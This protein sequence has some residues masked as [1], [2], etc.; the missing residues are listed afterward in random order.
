M[1]KFISGF[2]IGALLF[3]TIPVF[4]D[5]INNLVGKKVDGVYTVQTS[6]G[7]KIADAAVINGSTYAPVR[8]VAEATG[9]TLTVEGKVITLG[10]TEVSTTNINAL[11]DEL[12]MANLRLT[13]AQKQLTKSQEKLA[14]FDENYAKYQKK[15]DI[16]MDSGNPDFINPAKKALEDLGDRSKYEN[17]I[18]EAEES[19]TTATNDIKQIESQLSELQK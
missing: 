10:E 2:V 14:K 11:N 8:A 5:T 6:D 9:T 12:K 15:L 17:E 18:K 1:K 16:A 4:A 19:I 3:G 13:T 7:K